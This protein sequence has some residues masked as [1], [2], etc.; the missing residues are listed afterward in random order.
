MVNQV[1]HKRYQKEVERDSARLRLA[2]IALA[3]HN[4]SI[5]HPR[6]TP[7][8]EVSVD[9]VDR[10]L[11]ALARSDCIAEHGAMEAAVKRE[12]LLS[13]SGLMLP[14][15]DRRAAFYHLRKR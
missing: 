5:I 4:G 9:E 13:N 11:A 8:A 2:A 14:R 12:D 7:A 15:A 1:L 6:V 3:M 10:A